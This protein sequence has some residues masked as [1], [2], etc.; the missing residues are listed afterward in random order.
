MNNLEAYKMDGLGNDFIIFDNRKKSIFLTKNQIIK[1]SDRNNIGCDQVI[2][3]DQDKNHDA[4]LKFY[5]SDGG[6]ISACGNGSR[7]AAY[8]LMKENNQKKISL[9]TN[10]GILLGK[11][12]DKNLVSINIGQPNFEWNKIPL[13]KKMNNKNLEIK[14]NS[15]DG[16]EIK[17][18]FSLS[19]GNPHVVFFV[20]DLN[21]FDL[22]KIGPKI[23]SHSYF[24]EKCNVSLAS[25]KNKKHVKVKVWERGAGLTKA[26]GTAACAIAV[27][28]S[29]L[30]FNERCV[31]IEFSEGLLNIDWK[32]D[33]NIYMTGKVS[34]IEKIEVSI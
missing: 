20:E 5:N 3:I 11:L 18:G 27:S 12:N 15:I 9:K 14:I 8:F 16:K 10:A 29:I 4:F 34:G 32:K 21:K 23:E 1:I 25:V 33:N 19:V 31:D 7:C 28:G 24:P 26:C 6:E 30:Q 17:G 2:F 13:I 22:E